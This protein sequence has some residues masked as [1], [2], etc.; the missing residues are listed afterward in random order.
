MTRFAAVI[1]Y[2]GTAYHGWQRQLDES[3]TVQACVEKAISKVADHPVTVIC[4]G[5]TDAGVHAVGQVIHF[6]TT[7]KRTLRAWQFGANTFLPKDISVRSIQEV[8]ESFHARFSAI[9][10]RYQYRI[11]NHPVRSALHRQYA[12]WYCLPLDV[13]A[14]QQAAEALV[15][16]HDFSSFRAQSCQAK[17]PIRTIE[18]LTVT[19]HD[20]LIL[21][22]IQANAFLHHMVRNIAGV[23]MAIGAGKNPVSWTQEL[24]AAKSR[25]AGG[26]TA[27]PQGLHFMEAIYPDRSFL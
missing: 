10:R 12:T 13:A 14:M 3:A 1:E 17:S 4:A 5:R 6:D 19:V 2:D 21:I 25:A 7:A 18:H 22:D 20:D 8:D 24:L 11:F 23:L 26:V 9:A 16:E 27:L 15:G